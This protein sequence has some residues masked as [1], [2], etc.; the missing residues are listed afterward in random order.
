MDAVVQSDDYATYTKDDI[1]QYYGKL[2]V[3]S[4]FDLPKSDYLQYKKYVS[5]NT[6]NVIVHPAYFIFFQDNNQNKIYVE[7]RDDF[8]RNLVDLFIEKYPADEGSIQAQMKLSLKKE[9]QFL[10]EKAQKQDLVVL[11]LPP[12]YR[13]HP[14]Y[15]YK[16]LDE[17]G[18]YLNEVTKGS[19][20]V[21]Y[22]ESDDFKNGYLSSSTLTILNKFF[23]ALD[24]RTIR[25]GGGYKNLCL[26]NFSDDIAAVR[27]VQT[28]ELVPEIC[29]V[30]PDVIRN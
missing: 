16:K 22:V 18:R 13:G 30:S 24:I 17:F 15:P 26:K 1:D 12:R 6:V 11:V 23:N 19:P 8:S 10:R 9:S 21:L 4:L 7:R 29:T 5:G 27:N 28:I 14:E 2:N 3:R 25:I 20:S